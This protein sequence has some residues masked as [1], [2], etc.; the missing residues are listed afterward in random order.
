MNEDAYP[1][2]HTVQTRNGPKRLEE[3]STEELRE[4]VVMLARQLE[5]ARALEQGTLEIM[6]LVLR[7][8]K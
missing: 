3:C 2:V 6:S 4:L 7:S 5:D 8:K 1:Y